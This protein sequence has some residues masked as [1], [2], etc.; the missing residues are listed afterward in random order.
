MLEPKIEGR[1]RSWLGP[2]FD[3]NVRREIDDLLEAGAWDELTDRFYQDL[4]FG[5]G[6]LRGVLGAGTNRMNEYVIRM[7][8]QGLAD[9]VLSHGSGTLSG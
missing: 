8:T 5:T 9:Y 7:T 2:G 3:E 1:M 6:G 4:E